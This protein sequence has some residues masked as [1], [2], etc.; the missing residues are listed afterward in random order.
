M[1]IR[2]ACTLKRLRSVKMKMGET[3]KTYYKVVKKICRNDRHYG[4]FS[5]VACGIASKEYKTG[6]KTMPL[7][8][9]ALLAFATF[10]DARKFKE[11]NLKDGVIVSGT[12]TRT[13]LC[14]WTPFDLSWVYA[15]NG[16]EDR[17]KRHWLQKSRKG[18]PKGH[19][20]YDWP[21]Y[22]TLNPLEKS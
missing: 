11:S 12:G 8:G 20:Y 2:A 3:M 19:T 5:A 10:S 21:K 14:D 1:A 16:N 9:T 6:Q 15:N 17:I 22:K 7:P 4:F 13:S 18:K